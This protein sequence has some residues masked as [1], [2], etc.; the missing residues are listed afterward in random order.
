MSAPPGLPKDILGRLNGAL[1]K[2]VQMPDI[3][4]ALDKQGF[5]AHASTPEQFAALIHREIERTAKLIK[6]TGLKVE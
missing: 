4:E 2:I 6:L 1:V 5:E 3:K